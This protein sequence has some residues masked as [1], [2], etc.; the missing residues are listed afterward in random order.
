MA[1]VDSGIPEGFVTEGQLHRPSRNI[2]LCFD[3]T[4]NRYRGDGRETNVLK[5]FRLLDK[6]AAHQCEILSPLFVSKHETDL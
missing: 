1:P 4:G 2:V 3:G 6:D 5:I